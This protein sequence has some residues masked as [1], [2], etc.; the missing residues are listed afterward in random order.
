MKRFLSSPFGYSA[1]LLLLALICY[2]I[3]YILY[4]KFGLIAKFYLF[5]YLLIFL[6]FINF[7]NHI[8]IIKKTEKSPKKFFGVYLISTTVRLMIYLLIAVSSFFMLKE[9]IK[10]FL[11]S[12][13]FLYIGFTFFE[14]YSLMNYFKNKG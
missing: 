7:I 3:G 2:V 6:F 4:L 10:V 1:K 5:Q 8:V 11:I 9:E 14:T 13:M 12:F